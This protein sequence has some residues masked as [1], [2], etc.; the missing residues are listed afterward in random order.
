MHILITGASGFI[1]SQIVTDLLAAKHTVT[2]CVRNIAYTKR[3]FPG[4]NAIACDFRRDTDPSIWL[5]RL[6]NVDIVINCVGIL[7][8]PNKKVI[9]ATHYE[10][11]KA[12]FAAC[13]TAG[14]KRILQFSALGVE[15]CSVDY[16]ASKKALD[17]YLLTLPIPTLILRPSL[18]YGRGSYGGTS[19]FRGL[20]GL[21]YVTPVPGLGD[22]SFQPIHIEEL[23]QA[24][25]RFLTLPLDKNKIISVVGPEQIQLKDL[26][27]KLRTWLGFAPSLPMFVPLWL[28]KIGAFF[29]NLLPNS[30]LNKTAYKM[31]MQNNVAPELETSK[32][33]HLL[34]F[35]PANF[36]QGLYRY[37]STV[38]D[39]WH[40]RL[41]F[42]KPALQFG[43][44]F[45]WL[46][47]GL[48]GFVVPE[49]FHTLLAPLALSPSSE[50]LLIFGTSV[51]N[52]LCALAL[53]LG[54]KQQKVCLFQ[55]T[56]LLL[57]T[58]L[59]A[60]VLPTLLTDPLAALIKNIP[61]VISILIFLSLCSDR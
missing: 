43:L 41:Y 59:F 28:I 37:P 40:A 17:D 39:H 55:L 51:F 57:T 29:G 32:F 26:L 22:Q 10:T 54:F 46:F 5:K 12:L 38:Q 4:A 42:L 33:H 6:K 35:I 56:Y 58:S 50:S 27:S 18:V 9:W 31:L 24:I 25:L 60:W 15:T 48:L 34:G 11:P 47:S 7:Y 16:A 13:V 8:H 1:A 21:P 30:S 44:G 61:I 23:S 52:I 14:I 2:C 20:A 36:E 19:L 45:Y 49:H 3:L 53:M